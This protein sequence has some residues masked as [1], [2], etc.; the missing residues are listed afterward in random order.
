MISL[1]PPLFF[2]IISTFLCSSPIAPFTLL[3][4]HYLC[5]F[6]TTRPLISCIYY[7]ICVLKHWISSYNYMG[8]VGMV[9]VE[10]RGLGVISY[11]LE[12]QISKPENLISG[13][14][15]ITLHQAQSRSFGN[16]ASATA[17]EGEPAEKGLLQEFQLGSSIAHRGLNCHCLPYHTGYLMSADVT[18]Y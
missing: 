10:T 16:L 2:Y 18:F 11:M 17:Q 9:G 6:V 13:A 4:V 1:Y 8:L 7:L 14:G 12:P 3:V 5:L 15:M